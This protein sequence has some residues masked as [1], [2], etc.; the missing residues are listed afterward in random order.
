[1]VGQSVECDRYAQDSSRGRDDERQEEDASDDLSKRYTADKLGH[2]CDTVASR[3]TVTEIA[4]H[5]RAVCIQGHETDD[6]DG[7]RSGSERKES[8]WDAQ[9]TSCEDHWIKIVS[10]FVF[11]AAMQESGI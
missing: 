2:V 11:A 10:A 9:D 8:S 5:H 6:A 3:M 7:T 1:M 4:Q